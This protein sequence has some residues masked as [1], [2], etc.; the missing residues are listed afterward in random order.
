MKKCW[1]CGTDIES[2]PKSLYVLALEKHRNEVVSNLVRAEEWDQGFIDG[3][4]VAS[5]I[6]RRMP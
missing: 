6:I 5:D 4:R 1:N 3:L 2:D